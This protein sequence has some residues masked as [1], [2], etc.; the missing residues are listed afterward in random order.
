MFCC[1][2]GAFISQEN[3]CQQRS[4]RF[5]GTRGRTPSLGWV[6]RSGSQSALPGLPQGA[7]VL[8]LNSHVLRAPF[9]PGRPGLRVIPFQEQVKNPLGSDRNANS[10]PALDLLSQNLRPCRAAKGC[11]LAPGGAG[12][13][14]RLAGAQGGLEFSRSTSGAQWLG[15][16]ADLWSDHRLSALTC[17]DSG[18]WV[19]P[20]G[21]RPPSRLPF[22][23]GTL[24][25]FPA[26]GPC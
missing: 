26:G 8:K 14:A 6:L 16:P 3:V 22:H 12:V 5:I 2:P 18:G 19:F 4:G 15:K 20:A 11:A 21:S 10:G 7:S 23:V 1:L 13:Q 9:V 24:S 25:V 17:Q